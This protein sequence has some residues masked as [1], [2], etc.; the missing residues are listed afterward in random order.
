MD[1]NIWVI[2]LKL[3]ADQKGRQAEKQAQ[4]FLE[5]K[6]YKIITQRYKS[7]WGEIDLIAA[8]E[9]TLIAVEVKYRR[10]YNDA[11]SSISLRQKKRILNTLRYF[12][13]EYQDVNLK[14]PFLR[15][16]VVLLSDLTNP[17]HIM[18]AWQ[19]QDDIYEFQ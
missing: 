1:E 6:G 3:T 18:N 9:E 17:I 13:S 5:L 2:S 8:H 19:T 11:A 12:I 16:D 7:K 4:Q 14:Y 10:Y 15:I